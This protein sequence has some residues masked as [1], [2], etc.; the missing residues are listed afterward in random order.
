[1][2]D[3]PHEFIGGLSGA[4]IIGASAVGAPFKKR[5]GDR[6]IAVTSKVQGGR[7]SKTAVPVLY[8]KRQRQFI[9]PA[10]REENHNPHM[11]NVWPGRPEEKHC[12]SISPIWQI[13]EANSSR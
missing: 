13:A 2:A 12:A 8:L 11:S 1:M 6:V 10:T 5:C 3:P 4:P 7:P 9:T